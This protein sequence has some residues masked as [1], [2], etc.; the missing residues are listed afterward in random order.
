MPIKVLDSQSV[1]CVLL[2]GWWI[3]RLQMR[4][5]INSYEEHRKDVRLDDMVIDEMVWMRHP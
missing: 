1:M 3:C 5:R 4:Q 2:A